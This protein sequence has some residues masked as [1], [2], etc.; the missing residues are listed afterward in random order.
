MLKRQVLK[1]IASVLAIICV[2]NVFGMFTLNVSAECNVNINPNGL[3]VSNGEYPVVDGYNL[4]VLNSS[5]IP[6]VNIYFWDKETGLEYEEWPG[7]S[8]RSLSNSYDMVQLHYYYVPEEYNA[9]VFNYRYGLNQSVDVDITGN[10]G[11]MFDEVV[12]DL[13]TVDYWSPDFCQPTILPAQLGGAV[14]VW[15]GLPMSK[16]EGTENTYYY[17]IPTE[18]DSFIFSDGNFYFGFNDGLAWQTEDILFSGS[19]IYT[20][21][22]NDTWFDTSFTYCS[23]S[24]IDYGDDSESRRVYFEAPS[25]WETPSCFCWASEGYIDTPSDITGFSSQ[26]DGWSFVNHFEGFDYPDDGSYYIPFER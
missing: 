1:V 20:P 14:D 7:V 6:D 11:V 19:K 3:T 16:V 2:V 4:I 9:C 17:D 13:W 22:L 24:S 18:Y 12:D 8:M 15:P 21:N 5:H 23:V 10:M 25:S 26:N